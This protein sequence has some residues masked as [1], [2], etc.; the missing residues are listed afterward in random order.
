MQVDS[1]PISFSPMM[2]R[3]TLQRRKT[4]TR[5]IISRLP[6]YGQ[7]ANLKRSPGAWSFTSGGKQF[8]CSDAGMLAILPYWKGQQLWGQEAWRTL[9]SF[10]RLQPSQLP[11]DAPTFFEADC[12]GVAPENAGVLRPEKT[13]PR[14]RARLRLSVEHVSI[15]FIG[16]MSRENVL[17][18]GVSQFQVVGQEPKYSGTDELHIGTFKPENWH[19]N[20]F[21]AF[22]DLWDSVHVAEEKKFL[23]VSW[24]MAIKYRL[25]FGRYSNRKIFA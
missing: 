7:I 18:E 22:V 15:E 5:R 11:E 4:E 10:D 24:V 21:T 1:F 2:V 3:A 17:A 25:P 23:N 9:K 12:L 8:K 6:G 13:L 16:Q 14:E 19:Q 20:P